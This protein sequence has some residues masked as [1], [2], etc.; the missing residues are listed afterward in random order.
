MSYIFQGSDFSDFLANAGAEATNRFPSD[1]HDHGQINLQTSKGKI[2]YQEQR[3]KEKL[4]ILQG[5]YHFNDDITIFG[6]GESDLLEMHFNLSEGDI[7]YYNQT[8]NRQI[9]PAMSGNITYLSAAE[10]EARIAFH[11][12]L[13]YQTFDV[14]LPLSVLAV[15]AGESKA[16][17]AFL[18]SIDRQLS[19]TLSAREV[20]VSPRIYSTIQAIKNCTFVGLTKKIFLE[21]KIYELIA[22]LHDGSESYDAGARLSGSDEERIRYAA[23]L[24]RENLNHPL[25]IVELARQVGVNQTKLK[26]GFKLV[27]G[28]TVF[29]YLQETRM[30]MARELLLGSSMTVQHISSLS[31]YK[32]ISNFSAAFK[33]THGYSPNRLRVK[34]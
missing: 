30:H 12:D 14:H 28:T 15:Y 33:Q 4:S 26:Q 21:A 9:A 19:T 32:S 6:K 7:Y 17:D 24:I 11:K 25:T 10:N 5:N 27:F 34:G 29:G 2:S 31:G 23:A 3:V 1:F 8:L 16:M 20:K 13:S 22:Y 18:N